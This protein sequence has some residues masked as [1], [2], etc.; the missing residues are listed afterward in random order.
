[1]GDDFDF[2]PPSVILVDHVASELLRMIRLDILDSISH[3][4]VADEDI[5][6]ADDVACDFGFLDIGRGPCYD[7]CYRDLVMRDG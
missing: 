1:M 3:P 6:L 2:S 4:L 5:G 7:I